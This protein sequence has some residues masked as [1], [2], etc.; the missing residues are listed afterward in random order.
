MFCRQCGTQSDASSQFCSK[1]GAAISVSATQAGSA[2]P[3]YKARTDASPG[4]SPTRPPEPVS[5]TTEAVSLTAPL[6]ETLSA[7]ET[8]L[9]ALGERAIAA[10]LDTFAIFILLAPVGVWAARRWGGMTLDGFEL[11]GTA[12][13]F[14]IWILSILWFLYNWLFEGVLGATLGK[15]IMNLRVRRLNGSK[16]GL[17]ESFA[18]NLLRIIDAVGLYLVGF[19]VALFSRERQRLGDHAAGTR[20]VQGSPGN[21]VRVAATLALAAVIATCIVTAYKL[22]ASAPLTAQLS[23]STTFVPRVT[24]ANVPATITPRV[25]RAEMGTASTEEYQIIGPSTEFY[26]DTPEIV[27]V[28]QI[29]GTDAGT[30]IKSVWIAEDVGNGVPPDYQVAERSMSGANEGKFYISRP[31]NG[32]PPGKYRLEIYI[33]DNRAKQIPFI[34]KAR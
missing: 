13:Q 9:A 24:Q 7:G 32:W 15:L 27:C 23:P 30:L 6:S 17:R 21:F 2:S 18:R 33:S 31:N 11:H 8:V 3:A 20:V 10:G 26:T 25:T 1:C 29:A 22:H 12:A 16:I 14:T 28:W 19:L 4:I 34:I 5:S